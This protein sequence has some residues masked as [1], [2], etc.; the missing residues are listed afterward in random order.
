MTPWA[1]ALQA[2][3]FVNFSRQEY[4]NQLPRPMPGDLPNLGIEPV[5][6]ASPEL[7]GGFFILMETEISMLISNNRLQGESTRDKSYILL[8]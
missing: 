6:L 3:P 8:R 5:S 7:T 4:W 2:P 1:V